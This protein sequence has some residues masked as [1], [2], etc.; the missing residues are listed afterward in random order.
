MLPKIYEDFVCLHLKDPE[1]ARFDH[2]TC[3]LTFFDWGSAAETYNEWR[4]TNKSNCNKLI[5]SKQKEALKKALLYGDR[6]QIH[7]KTDSPTS[8]KTEI[9]F[10]IRDENIFNILSGIK[11][12][13]V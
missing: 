5:L 12:R 8:G 13:I 2:N 10:L 1:F 3:T 9:S 7:K 6:A 11:V 4:K